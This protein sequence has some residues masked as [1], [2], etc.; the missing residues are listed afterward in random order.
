MVK[1]WEKDN[2]GLD[3]NQRATPQRMIELN[4]NTA[5]QDIRR[6][7]YYSGN[8][9]KYEKNTQSIQV[10]NENTGNL[11]KRKRNFALKEGQEEEPLEN[12][13]QSL[14]FDKNNEDHRKPPERNPF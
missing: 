7:D 5:Q 9:D 1:D 3:D 8:Q 13:Y 10:R 11:V 2:G 4:S 14:E 6:V 12:V